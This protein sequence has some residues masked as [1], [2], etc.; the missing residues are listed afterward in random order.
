MLPVAQ[1]IVKNGIEVLFRRV[2]G[3]QQVVVEL[4]LVNGPD[5]RVGIGV[6][7]EQDALRLGVRAHGPRQ[8]LDAVHLRHAVIHQ[9]QRHRLMTLVEP[10]EQIEGGLTRAGGEHA[11]VF[12]VV[13]AQV[14]L[15]AFQHLRIVIDC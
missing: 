14:A 3:L 13:F 8:E 5:G 9:K 2:P 10:F 15:D 11:V 1:Q 12:S 7:R 4:D 6:G